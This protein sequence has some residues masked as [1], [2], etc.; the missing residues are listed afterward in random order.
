MEARNSRGRASLRCERTAS[1]ARRHLAESIQRLRQESH[2]YD[3]AYL[4]P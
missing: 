4:E 3:S 1:E 2:A